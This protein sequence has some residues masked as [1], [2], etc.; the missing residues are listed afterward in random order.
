MSKRAAAVARTRQR[1][2]DA[3]REL[4]GEHGIAATSWDDIAARAGVGVGTVYRHFPTLD[5]LIPACGDITMQVVALPDPPSVP[6]LFEHATE[7]AERIE[8]L[9]REAFAI[10][11]RGAA[12]LRA[13]RREGDAHPRVAQDRDAFEASLSALVDTAFEPLDA[14]QH[15][16]AVARAMVDLNTWEALRDQGLGP[17]E[18]VAAIGDMLARRFASVRAVPLSGSSRRAD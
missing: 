14:T 2:V 6:A 16:R 17:A 11:E 5:E 8:R 15:D 3:T 12:E 18:S 13:I 7:P 10:Y 1:I 9:V 4:H